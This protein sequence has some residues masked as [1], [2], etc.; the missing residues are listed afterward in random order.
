MSRIAKY[1]E[2]K[3]MA[4]KYSAD[5]NPVVKELTTRNLTIET[6]H[7]ELSAEVV[8]ALSDICSFSMERRPKPKGSSNPNESVHY[9]HEHRGQLF[10]ELRTH[11][12][13]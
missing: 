10:H 8:M 6:N 5:S 13:G 1:N 7:T 11:K 3:K 2:S 9:C 4:I 12:I